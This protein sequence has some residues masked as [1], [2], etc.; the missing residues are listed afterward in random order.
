[1]AIKI[2]WLANK[3]HNHMMSLPDVVIPRTMLQE[4]SISIYCRPND[5]KKRAYHDTDTPR[6]ESSSID[7]YNPTPLNAMHAVKELDTNLYLSV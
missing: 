1:M 2:D 7:M 4:R 3:A 5:T 6:S